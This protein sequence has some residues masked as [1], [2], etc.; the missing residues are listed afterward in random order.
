MQ[1]AATS[2]SKAMDQEKCYTKCVNLD[3]HQGFYKIFLGE[4]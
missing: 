3:I 1:K 2:L 4:L